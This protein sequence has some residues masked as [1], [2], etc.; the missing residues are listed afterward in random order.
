MLPEMTASLPMFFPEAASLAPEVEPSASPRRGES[1]PISGSGPCS[2]V[3]IVDVRHYGRP[4]ASRAVRLREWL[5]KCFPRFAAFVGIRRAQEDGK[6]AV[7]V[8][9]IKSAYALMESADKLGQV[10]SK[11]KIADDRIEANGVYIERLKKALVAQRAAFVELRKERDELQERSNAWQ[12]MYCSTWDAELDR[13]ASEADALADKMQA[14]ADA[15]AVKGVLNASIGDARL[16]GA[17]F[18][19]LAAGTAEPALFEVQANAAH[20]MEASWHSNESGYA[21]RGASPPESDLEDVVG[22]I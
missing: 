15:M 14:E 13:L 9:R 12:I 19:L 17:D 8:E 1:A 18:G 10:E 4:R 20:P 22:E 11:L 21:T 7:Y 16:M 2:N 5:Y 6:A 3:E